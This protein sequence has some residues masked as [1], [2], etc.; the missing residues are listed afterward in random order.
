MTRHDMT[1]EHVALVIRGDLPEGALLVK[2][3]YDMTETYPFVKP[4]NPFDQGEI[5]QAEKVNHQL[6]EVLT[7]VVELT[8]N[9]RTTLRPEYKVF[10]CDFCSNIDAEHYFNIPHSPDCL[11]LKARDILHQADVFTAFDSFVQEEDTK[12]MLQQEQY[13]AGTYGDVDTGLSS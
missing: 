6:I 5:D 9:T 2:G 13:E 4:G 3:A 12:T 11:V 8:G 7:G 1:G 10:M